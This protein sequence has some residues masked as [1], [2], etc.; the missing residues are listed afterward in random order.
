MRHEPRGLGPR[1]LGLDLDLYRRRVPI[2][3]I[4]GATLSAVDLEA[5][6]VERC[7]VFVH[8][9]AG[10]AETWEPQIRALATRY[11]VVAPELRGH[12]QSDAPYSRYDMP[13]LVSDLESLC[14]ALDLPPRFVMVGHSFGGAVALEFA[15]R[16]PDRLQRLILVATP[17]RFPL[18]AS[19]GL[20]SRVPT[21]VFRPVWRFRRRWNAEPHVLKRMILDN[22]RH[23]DG[24]PLL[25]RLS[26]PTLL[27]T[28]QR[29]TYFPRAVM[30]GMVEGLPQAER[31]DVGASK[32]K[33]QLERHEAVSR[34]IERFCE[35][36]RSRSWREPPI[37]AALVERRPWLGQYAAGTPATVP[38][39]R[40]PLHAFLQRSAARVP[41]RTAVDCGGRKRS[42]AQLY[43]A[44]NQISRA[45][46][47]LGLHPGDRVA[48]LLPNIPELPEAFFGILG[49]GMTVV[50]PSSDGDANILA[51]EL[52]DV[53]ARILICAAESGVSE[54][55]PTYP[56]LERLARS[57]LK[58]LLRVGGPPRTR[59]N[60]TLTVGETGLLELD[61]N[62]LLADVDDGPTA[63]AVDLEAPALIRFIGEEAGTRR[64]TCLSH[65]QV[66]ANAVQCRH[67]MPA[68][69][70]GSSRFLSALPLT[71]DQ[72][73]TLGLALPVLL[74]ATIQLLPGSG[75]DAL[76]AEL[77]RQ[78]PDILIGRPA[79]YADLCEQPKLREAGLDRLAACL[80]GGA[81]LPVELQERFEKLARCRLTESYGPSEACAVT[82]AN[83]IGR[84]RRIGS[85]GLPLP[86]TDARIVDPVGRADLPAGHVGLL[87]VRG[88]QVADGGDS[89][90][91][92]TDDLAL[93]E[94]DGFFRLIGS[95]QDR[96]ETEQGSVFARD[97]EELL[98][99]QAEL[100]E[101][102][103]LS[104][105]CAG[106]GREFV[107]YV[108][109][110]G[111][112]RHQLD[113][114]CA[115]L[116][117][118]LPK[119]ARPAEMHL[120]DSLPRRKSGK[121]DRRALASLPRPAARTRGPQS[122]N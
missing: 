68:I 92:D 88:P 66:V 90:W 112:D 30:E 38:L 22:M 118:R 93:M 77:L 19:I 12:G 97:V 33:V 86:N 80:S 78:R 17:I 45:L 98:Y 117:R 81:A 79:T 37:D 51:Q 102:A 57:G 108:V 42:Y 3:G 14:E 122:P 11:R 104:R 34:A 85:I 107:A 83:P 99:E 105:A 43:K 56:A 115:K 49:A 62:R 95:P 9:L 52:R 13:E 36:G 8:G 89:D 55:G 47:G 72:G 6:G 2:R 59:P 101:A 110:G 10:C 94:P 100:R 35:S 106:G 24:G 54:T 26:M 76:F 29:D 119:A 96:V 48:L 20:L 61:L 27:L 67:W 116:A 58:A 4:A 91:L 69:A 113:D 111:P 71:Q 50:L 23:W 18:P 32:H 39:P 75:T 5:E 53:G 120:L 60:A 1:A 64:P 84:G 44:S 82:H 109:L 15:A 46:A 73:V 7:I 103:V 41:R 16:H 114:L 25:T 21:A 87:L 40:Q 31:V 121:L 70:Y 74:G 63:S 28:G 65:A